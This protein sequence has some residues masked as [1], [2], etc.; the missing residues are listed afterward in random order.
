MKK[1]D[2]SQ[3]LRARLSQEYFQQM[4][5]FINEVYHQGRIYPDEDKIF[6]AI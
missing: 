6:S 2:W 5:D 3:P 4:I 1:T